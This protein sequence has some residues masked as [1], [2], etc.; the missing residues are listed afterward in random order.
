MAKHRFV[1]VTQPDCRY[2]EDAKR[3]L[4]A[5]NIPYEEVPAN[6]FTKGFLKALDLTTVPQV[7]ELID[8]RGEGTLPY[9]VGGFTDLEEWILLCEG[10][11]RID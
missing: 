2:C 1:I 4:Q 10:E 7:W 11:H 3:L 6:V 8:F 9:Y 5:R